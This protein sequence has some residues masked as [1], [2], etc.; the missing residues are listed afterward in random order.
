MQ[1]LKREI[2]QQRTRFL[3]GP[4]G[5]SKGVKWGR[6]F[7]WNVLK[8][9]SDLIEYSGNCR[10]TSST[11]HSIIYIYTHIFYARIR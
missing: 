8:K 2:T 5:V 1:F 9:N 11:L 4:R 7:Q 3:T 10:Q 6:N